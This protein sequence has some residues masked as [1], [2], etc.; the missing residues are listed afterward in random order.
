MIK[1]INEKVYYKEGDN[2]YGTN[3]NGDAFKVTQPVLLAKLNI[4]GLGDVVSTITKAL[5]IRECEECKKRRETLNSIFSWTRTKKVRDLTEEEIEYITNIKDGSPSK[6]LFDIYNS[7]F[8]SNLE[9]C[10]CPGLIKVMLDRVRLVLDIQ[11]DE[12]NIIE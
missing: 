10:N 3:K 5:N 1:T 11:L 9:L 12:K 2:W 7:L 8:Y 4:E 6:P